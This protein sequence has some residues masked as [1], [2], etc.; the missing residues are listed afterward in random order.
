M[1]NSSQSI[2]ESETFVISVPSNELL[3]QTA[4]DLNITNTR[5][6]RKL[7]LSES[8]NKTLYI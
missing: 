7:I 5:T 1:P 4:N 2:F 6:K 8:E 3:F